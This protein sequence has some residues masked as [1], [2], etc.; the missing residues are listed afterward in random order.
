MLVVGACALSC[1][2]LMVKMSCCDVSRADCVRLGEV[3]CWMSCATVERLSWM[4]P[5]REPVLFQAC[6]SFL[7]CLTVYGGAFVCPLCLAGVLCGK[8]PGATF[9]RG[10]D[11]EVRRTPPQC[12]ELSFGLAQSSRVRRITQ[13]IAGNPTAYMVNGS[14][15]GSL[16]RVRTPWQEERVAVS[17]EFSFLR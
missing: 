14:V 13:T 1:V 16:D 12:Q 3:C 17:A 15:A 7:G 10:L 9:I 11:G 2:S 6:R 4:C 8:T 5:D